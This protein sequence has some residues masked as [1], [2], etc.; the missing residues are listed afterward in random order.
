LRL[1][2]TDVTPHKK[3]RLKTAFERET[4]LVAVGNQVGTSHKRS[5]YALRTTHKN[6]VL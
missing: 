2:L 6:T 1:V 3:K 5:G 4:D